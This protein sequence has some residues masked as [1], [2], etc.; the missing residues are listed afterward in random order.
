MANSNVS[1]LWAERRRCWPT[2]STGGEVLGIIQ[3]PSCSIPQLLDRFSK[4]PRLVASQWLSL[5]PN[6][7]SYRTGFLSFS[8]MGGISSTLS[9]V[10]P[11]R[12]STP[13]H[14]ME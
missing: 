6:P 1:I 2:P 9:K 5:E 14:L 13:V 10:V 3:E 8:P 7:D 11:V 4:Y 12:V